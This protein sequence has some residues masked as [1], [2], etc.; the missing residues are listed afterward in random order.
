[1]ASEETKHWK[2]HHLGVIVGDM[3]KAVEYY[4]SLGIVDFPPETGESGP[5]RPPSSL[6]GFPRK[7]SGHKSKV[8]HRLRRAKHPVLSWERIG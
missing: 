6:P 2:F 8:P 3:D 5:A 1:M 4:Q 7:R